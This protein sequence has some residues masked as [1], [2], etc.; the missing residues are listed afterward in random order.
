MFAPS[1][2]CWGLSPQVRGS[3]DA[4][5]WI[6]D[7]LGSIPAGAGEPISTRVTRSRV[8]VY[9]RRCGG[10]S[11]TSATTRTRTGLSPQVR[12]SLNEVGCLAQR[13]GSIPAG[14]GE[15]RTNHRRP[16]T[17]SVYPRRCGGALYNA[18]TFARCRGLSPQVRGSRR[19]A[20]GIT[21]RLGSIPAGA[22]E[23]RPARRCRTPGRVYPRR[24]GGASGMVYTALGSSGLS[25]QVRGSLFNQY[26]TGP[27]AGS[28]PAGAGE[29]ET[30][31][32]SR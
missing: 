32:G 10:A 7:G 26:V 11:T 1:A 16:R 31:P 25:P 5:V 15:P 9:P 20:S 27:A 29:P 14:A 30:M 22:G 21:I 24:C 6:A 3:H 2:P 17:R 19:L 8:R 12:G 4:G 13:V 28:I 18:G 23:P